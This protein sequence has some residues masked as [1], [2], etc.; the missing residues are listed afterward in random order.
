MVKKTNPATNG[1]AAGK[2][3]QDIGL[4]NEEALLECI[5][6]Q[7]WVREREASLITGMSDY[8]VGVV[9]RRLKGKG[10]IF[11]DRTHGNAGY[12]LRLTSKGAERAGGKSGKDI[13]IPD[14]W[15]HHALAVQTLHFLAGIHQCEFETEASMRR[16]IR[17][18]KFPDGKLVSWLR[19]YFEQELSRKSGPLLHKQVETVV[20]LAKEGYICHIAYPYPAAVCGGIDHET[21]QTNAIRHLWGSPDASNI[22]LVRCYFDSALAFHNMRPSRFEIIDLPSMVNTPAS[23]KPQPGITEQVMGFKWEC[24]DINDPGQPRCTEAKLTH[25]GVL[26]FE[27]VFFAA[28]GILDPHYLEVDGWLID[29]SYDEDQPFQDFLSGHQKRIEKEIEAEMESVVGRYGL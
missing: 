21:R 10:E 26:K 16:R 15:R 7:G 17:D 3:G 14:C 2:N 4:A 24:C 29:K 19:F 5:R 12:F 25:N 22:K 9:G 8:T 28:E 13:S 20:R 23:R 18:G 27:G 11:R 6:M 1:H